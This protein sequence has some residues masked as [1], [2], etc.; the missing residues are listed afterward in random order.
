MLRDNERRT[1]EGILS[2]T[3]EAYEEWVN[4]RYRA[5]WDAES[6]QPDVSDSGGVMRSL[7]GGK[8]TDRFFG[9]DDNDKR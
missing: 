1:I 4:H 3:S 2:D 5:D 9:G 7:L 6:K 8:L